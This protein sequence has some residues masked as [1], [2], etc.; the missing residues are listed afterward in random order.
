MQINEKGNLK[1]TEH[2]K[3]ENIE[4]LLAGFDWAWSLAVMEMH[5]IARAAKTR[6][7]YL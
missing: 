3:Y 2:D 1:A 7:Q 6:F 4:I 5:I